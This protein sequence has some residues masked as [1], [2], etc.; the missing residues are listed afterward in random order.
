MEGKKVVEIHVPHAVAP[1]EH[2]GLTGE[3]RAEALDTAS[4]E[5]LDARVDQVDVPVGVHGSV[6][7]DVAG[8]EIDAE[9]ALQ[10]CQL[11]EILLDVLALVAERDIELPE[12]VAGVVHH[13]VPEDRTSAD[14]D[15]WLG[16]NLRLLDQAGP[17]AACEDRDL[18]KW[19][20]GWGL[21]A[22]NRAAP[23]AARG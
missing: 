9:V 11:H 7:L 5:R 22:K 18:H 17:D 16:P 6:T 2:E 13:D 21:I 3:V 10:R 15:H 23:G 12:P 14:L 19:P 8:P 1:G 20:A 4:G